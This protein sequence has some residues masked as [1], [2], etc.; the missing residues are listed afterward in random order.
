MHDD[1]KSFSRSLSQK[2]HKNSIDFEKPQSLSKIPK[3]RSENMKCMREWV[4]KIIPDER[5]WSLGWKSLAKEVLSEK[6]VFGRWKGTK[7]SREIEK[8]QSEIARTLYIEPLKSQKI[9]RCQKVLRF[10]FWPMHLSRS[11]LKV[12]TAKRGSMDRGVIEH[13][14]RRQKL[15]RW[16][17][18]LSRSY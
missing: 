4:K 10:K 7:V 9:K 16:I 15:S 3:V 1:L 12:S 18:E 2:F 11:Y 13:L 5:R 17:N 14:S 6:N 8:S